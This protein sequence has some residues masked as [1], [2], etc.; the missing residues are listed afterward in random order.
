MRWYG[1]WHGGSGYTAPGDEDLELFTSL[2]QARA[3]LISRHRYGYSQPQ[4]FSYLARPAER[5]LT[6]CVGDDCEI[7]LYP[8]SA[9]LSYPARRVYLGPRGAAR[10]EHC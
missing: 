1:L 5:V 10:T 2:R 8:S 6:P 4:D 7:L 3:R 9:G